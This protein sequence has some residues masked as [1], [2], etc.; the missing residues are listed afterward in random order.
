VATGNK[1]D[2]VRLFIFIQPHQCQQQQQQQQEQER[3][4]FNGRLHKRQAMPDHHHA[5]G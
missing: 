4:G 2:H 5:A 1:T 3:S